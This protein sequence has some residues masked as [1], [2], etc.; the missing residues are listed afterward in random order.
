MPFP[1]EPVRK[2]GY[3]GI[4]VSI[5][6]A[7]LSSELLP[8]QWKTFATTLF[9]LLGGGA[10]IESSRQGQNGSVGPVTHAEALSEREK[11][12]RLAIEAEN[13]KASQDWEAQILEVQE[14][15]L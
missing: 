10:G 3:A 9:I 13:V 15:Q 4:L 2:R 14:W 8:D 5:I 6:G 11:Q 12:V 7:A 1:N